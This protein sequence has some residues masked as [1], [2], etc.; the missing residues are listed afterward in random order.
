MDLQGF[1]INFRRGILDISLRNFVSLIFQVFI[2][3]LEKKA[4]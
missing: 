2:K 4:S 3:I 1:E